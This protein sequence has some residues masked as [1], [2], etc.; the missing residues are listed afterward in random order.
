MG[1]AQTPDPVIILTQGTETSLRGL[2]VVN[3]QTIWASGSNGYTARSNDGGKIFSF[4]QLYEYDKAELRDIHGFDSSTAIVM[5]SVQ[6]AALFKTS[7]GGKTWKKV[8]EDKTPEAFLDGFDFWDKKN[9]ICFG[10]PI[11]NRFMILT[12]TDGGETWNYIDS[13]NCP[14]VKDGT[15]AFAASG[16]SI[17]CLKNGD[18][19]FATGGT[20][21]VLFFSK[22]YGRNWKR[23][24]TPMPAGYQSSG[25]FSIDFLNEKEGCITGG[26][27]TKTNTKSDN[28][29]YTTN[30]GKSW[31]E[32]GTM[33]SGYRS[34]VKYVDGYFVVAC[35]TSGVDLGYTDSH[36]FFT[37]NTGN[38]N[39]LATDPQRKIIF[40]AGSNGL[41]ATMSKK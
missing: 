7:S 35:G 29:Y 21:S 19:Y 32:A 18:V 1:L 25:I 13:A 30:G 40:L 8:F 6:P 16:S 41:I 34:G 14:L 10:D 11:N 26:D 9:G 27:Y 28:F 37:V 38:Y 22:D 5:S 12:T 3:E 15:A 4:H 39:V 23:I 17:Q 24:E 20:E 31:K 2:S 36:H 33:P